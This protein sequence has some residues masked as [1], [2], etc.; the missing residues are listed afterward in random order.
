MLLLAAPFV[1]RGIGPA[2][3]KFVPIYQEKDEISHLSGFFRWALQT[4]ARTGAGATLLA[5]SLL[6]VFAWLAPDNPYGLALAITFLALPLFAL[7]MYYMNVSTCFNA[8]TSAFVIYQ[9]GL[10]ALLVLGS[11]G[12]SLFWNLNSSLALC[13][14]LV[15]ALA[16][17]W[18]AE[19]LSIG[20]RF[21]R[22]ILQEW[23]KSGADGWPEQI[24]EW[25]QVASSLFRTRVFEIVHFHAAVAVSGL[26]L[27]PELVSTVFVANRI[28]DLLTTIGF[29]ISF[30][31]APNLA[32]RAVDDPQKLKREYRA[33][34]LVLSGVLF[35][36]AMGL[37]LFRTWVL[38]LFGPEFL[39]ASSLLIVFVLGTYLAVLAM[40]A[41]YLLVA[42]GHH[43]ELLLSVAISGL[44]YVALLFMLTGVYGTMGVAAA[45]V[46]SAAARA[47]MLLFFTERNFRF[48]EYRKS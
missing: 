20:R 37:G 5:V 25:R 9:F 17:I 16:T 35:L 4:I 26:M 24:K 31:V 1:E 32:R 30:I 38:G 42:T 36:C 12:L 21:V 29:G 27:A 7:A 15:T 44:L 10:P 43:R 28:A 3:L 48:L 46:I 23:R 40:P 2:A 19:H 45:F 39:T 34:V 33:A 18:L 41:Q 6:L 47:S 11:I 13:G 22:P 8:T 14:L